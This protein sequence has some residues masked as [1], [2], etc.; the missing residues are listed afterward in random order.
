MVAAVTGHTAEYVG[1]E[2][3]MAQGLQYQAIWLEMQGYTTV[4][5]QNGGGA[6]LKWRK[7]AGC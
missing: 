4:R 6:E 5:C 7:I 1:W 2:M 3:P